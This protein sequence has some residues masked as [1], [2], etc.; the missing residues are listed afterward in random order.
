MHPQKRIWIKIGDFMA[1]ICMDLITIMA[2]LLG[3]QKKWVQCKHMCY[4]LQH[5]MYCK[6][7]EKFI[8]HS[9][10]NWNKI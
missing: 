2:S 3:K 10:W 5:V 8:L 4:I 6:Y 1:Y 7:M 9:I